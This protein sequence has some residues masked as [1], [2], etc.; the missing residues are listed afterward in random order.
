[1]KKLLKLSLVAMGVFSMLS[2]I[3]NEDEAV[4][5]CSDENEIEDGK[6]TGDKDEGI[7]LFDLR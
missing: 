5:L 6:N 3:N 2:L 1:M 4:K 7:I